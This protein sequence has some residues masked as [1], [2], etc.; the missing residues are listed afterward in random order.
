MNTVNVESRITVKHV[1]VY[2]KKNKFFVFVKLIFYSRCYTQ[3]YQRGLF[4]ESS[5]G[6]CSP[7]A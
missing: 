4:I 7:L 5:N 1:N 2:A 3:F 6:P